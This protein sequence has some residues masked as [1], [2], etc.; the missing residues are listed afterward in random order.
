MKILMVTSEL[1]PYAKVGGL[2]DMVSSLSKALSTCHHDV[3]VVCP[4]YGSIRKEASWSAHETPLVVNLGW[5]QK[6]YCRRW[7]GQLPGS[8]V[9]LYF[10]E[11]EQYYGRPEIYSGPW[12]AHA[13]NGER[14]AFLSRAALDLCYSL[15]WIPDVIHAH[16]WPGGLVPVYLNTLEEG[17]ALSRSASVFTVHNMKHHGL[18]ERSILDFAG[19]PDSVFKSDGLEAMGFVNF[20]KGGLYYA[21]KLSTVSPSYAK[22]MQTPEFGHGLDPAVRFRSGDLVGILNGIDLEHWSPEIDEY[23]P[24]RYSAQDLTGKLQCK[25]V[26]QKRLGLQ[27]DSHILTFAAIARM[28]PQKGLDLLAESIP[29]VMDSMH[30]QVI[31]LGMGE[32]DLEHWFLELSYRYPGR[33]AVYIGYDSALAHLIEAGA[34]V[35]IMPSRFEPCGLNQMYSMRYG[36]PPIVRATGGL[37]DTVSSYKEGTGKG[38]GFVFHE[39]SAEALYYTMGW[40]CSTYY[41]RPQEFR[42]LQINGMQEDFSWNHSARSYELLYQ[43]AVKSVSKFPH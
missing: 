42:A 37:L 25:H 33:V 35:F 22:E 4:L 3:R 15:D 17:K 43:W 21:T 6:G 26:L 13:D 8:K 32:Q 23:L 16:D 24:Q 40:A 31:I 1:A 38:T 41:D 14:F 10:L 34:D 28:D 2:A 18:F 20:L 11:H 5:G 7:E 36:T 30:A 39:A 27:E 29:R 9:K 12:G 19:L